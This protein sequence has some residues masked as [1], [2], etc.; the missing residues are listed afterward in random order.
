MNHFA[1]YLLFLV[2]LCL[3]LGAADTAM[4]DLGNEFTEAW[5]D[6][7]ALAD[8][9]QRRQYRS[10][11]QDLEKRFL[12][13]YRSDPGGAYAAKSIYY[14]GRVNQELG[15]QSSLSSDF[16]KAIDY[17]NRVASRFP[18][19][20]WTDDALFRAATIY[21]Y[22]LDKPEQAQAVLNSIISD[23]PQGDMLVRAEELMAEVQGGDLSAQ[24]PPDRESLPRVEP[25]DEPA[26]VPEPSAESGPSL[27]GDV[28]EY[29]SAQGPVTEAVAHAV[30][31]PVPYNGITLLN[32]VRYQSSD[33]YT[34]VVIDVNHEVTYTYQALAAD[35]ANDK[36]PRMYI[37][38][39][40][41]RLGPSVHNVAIS[42]G[43]LMR[44]RVGQYQPDVARVVL[45]FE[46][47]QQFQIFALNNPFRLIIDVSAPG[48]EP[49]QATQTVDAAPE[50]DPEALDAALAEAMQQNPPEEPHNEP[51]PPH[52]Q[53]QDNPQVA[54]VVPEPAPEYTP[55]PGSEDQTGTLVEQL[56]LTVQTIMLDAGHGGRDPGASGNGLV[57]K[58]VNLQFV[59]ILGELLTQRG[60]TVLYTRD[61]DEFIPLEDRSGM[62]NV[63]K[64]DLF[65][66]VHCNAFT[67]P[68]L[69]G[70]ETYS[71]NLASSEDAVRVAAR[72]N[73]GTT[74]SI[75]DLDVILTDLMLNSKI[76]ESQDLADTVHT[77]LVASSRQVYDIRDLGTRTAPFYVL[78]GAKMPA[79]LVELGYLTN[80][81]DAEHLADE[82][83]LRRMAAGLAQG[84]EDYKSKIEHFAALQ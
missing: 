2:G 16:H 70:L 4:A 77:S 43:I 6:F 14:A 75:S 5:N 35:P 26:D 13:I 30:T 38:L 36:P 83:Y 20:T 55:P 80:G 73:D 67:G 62:A 9:T 63:H 60:Y 17:Y 71:L 34:R 23:H 45:D 54:E 78:M 28:V 52:Y 40:D 68:G 59:L 41:T 39:H 11:W 22:H 84:I 8:D 65:I 72:E 12:D 29:A 49:G 69:H 10:N 33:E 24:L 47:M 76:N 66:S 1:R 7:H 32:E 3:L 27:E 74:R 18:G 58:E 48:T 51:E 25:S 53:G 81:T 37:D 42:D 56:G 44:V 21:L 19:H 82:D 31:E 46:D 15:V 61:S 64:A 57:E 50:A 79:I